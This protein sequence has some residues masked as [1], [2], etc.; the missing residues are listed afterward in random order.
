MPSIC[1]DATFKAFCTLIDQA[2]LTQTWAL[3]LYN[4]AYP[5]PRE[6]LCDRSFSSTIA[7]TEPGLH[8]NY[9]EIRTDA[10]LIGQS[11]DQRLRIAKIC[12]DLENAHRSYI[13]ARAC[14]E[15]YVLYDKMIDRF[16][17]KVTDEH[18]QA[19]IA[20]GNNGKTPMVWPRYEVVK[21][22]NR[23]KLNNWAV[24]LRE[25]TSNMHQI[26]NSPTIK[27][28][29][30]Q[31][32][33]ARR[34]R[35][36]SS[37]YATN[38]LPA[39]SRP[40]LTLEE[41]KVAIAR[42]NRIAEKARRRANESHRIEN[43]SNYHQIGEQGRHANSARTVAAITR[44]QKDFIA[45]QTEVKIQDLQPYRK[46]LE[47]EGMKAPLVELAL[48]EAKAALEADHAVDLS[49]HVEF[50]EGFRNVA[51]TGYEFEDQDPD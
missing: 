40:A 7:H 50:E 16:Y 13:Q 43:K 4:Q 20:A 10:R 5:D 12:N 37:R 11:P 42:R 18:F 48:E 45:K 38:T 31:L 19:F 2:Q 1:Q 9:A 28:F 29:L 26:K 15:G 14:V 33:V 21:E 25:Y 22:T 32:D 51:G 46:Q 36:A 17:R 24:Q 3:V 8:I 41:R 35:L 49:T 39:V 23:I 30:A 44:M 47:S 27:Q 6:L 34:D